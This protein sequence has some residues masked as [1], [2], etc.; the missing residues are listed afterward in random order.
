MNKLLVF[1]MNLNREKIN[2]SFLNKQSITNAQIKSNSQNQSRFD[3]I[4]KSSKLLKHSFF[5]NTKTQKEKAMKAINRADVQGKKVLLR[6]DFNVKVNNQ[7]IEDDS[8]IKAHMPTICK[9]ISWEPKNL[10][11]VSHLTMGLGNFPLTM[12]ALRIYSEKFSQNQFIVNNDPFPFTYHLAPN[13]TLLENIRISF[14]GE[15]KNSIIVSTLLAGIADVFVLDALSCAHRE[16]ASVCMVTKFL[17]SFAG[18]L[19]SR[20]VNT[21]SGILK[22]PKRPFVVIVGGSKI[23]DKE[24]VVKNLLKIADKI[25]CGGKVGNDLKEKGVYKNEPKIVLPVDGP[26]KDIG[27][28]TIELFSKEIKSARTILWAGP[29]GKFEEANFEKGTKNIAEIIAES[30]AFKIVAGGDTQSALIKFGMDKKMDFISQGGGATLEF[31]SGKRL[32]GLEALGFY[33]IK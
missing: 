8:R 2:A 32:P 5:D 9:F 23:E 14:P 11:I 17:P 20:E 24:P 12:V 18:P 27:P 25:L 16:H 15:T 19:L 3:F 13:V 29:L 7:G 22:T 28:A 10:I 1:K 30:K 4:F 31:L 21:L 26:P 6:V 33:K